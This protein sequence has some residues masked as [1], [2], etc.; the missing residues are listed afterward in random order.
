MK[1]C[2]CNVNLFNREDVRNNEGGKYLAN[3]KIWEPVVTSDDDCLIAVNCNPIAGVSSFFTVL[4]RSNGGP[5]YINRVVGNVSTFVPQPRNIGDLACREDTDGSWQWF[6]HGSPIYDFSFACVSD[7]N[8]CD[9]EPMEIMSDITPRM[10]DVHT[11]C[12]F[13]TSRCKNNEQVPFIFNQGT[14]IHPGSLD[15]WWTTQYEDLFCVKKDDGSFKW[16]FSNAELEYPTLYCFSNEQYYNESA[17]DYCGVFQVINNVDQFNDLSWRYLKGRYQNA[18][19]GVNNWQRGYYE[20]FDIT[21][22]EGFEPVIFTTNNEPLVLPKS[23]PTVKCTYN[24]MTNE[25][26]MWVANGTRLISP[27]AACVRLEITP[28][29]DMNGCKCPQIQY[30]SQQEIINMGGYSA[31]LG[32]RY[33]TSLPVTVSKQCQ[34][35]FDGNELFDIFVF[36]AVL[37]RDEA[38]P[39]IMRRFLPSVQ[40]H[41]NVTLQDLTC[42]KE[43][44][45]YQWNYKDSK[46][47]DQTLYLAFQANWGGC[48]CSEFK[49]DDTV[50]MT[51]GEG[52]CDIMKF[53]CK[54][55]L[56][57][58]EVSYI[59]KSGPNV[60][61]Q[62]VI[63]S[64]SSDLTLVGPFCNYDTWYINGIEVE[65]PVASCTENPTEPT[66]SNFAKT[67]PCSNPG[68]F[69]SPPESNFTSFWNKFSSYYP[70][71]E[72]FKNREAPYEMPPNYNTDGCRTTYSCLEDDTFVVFSMN[73]K[74]MIYPAGGK[75]PDMRCVVPPLAQNTVTERYWWIDNVMVSMPVFACFLRD[76]D[77][78]NPS[79]KCDKLIGSAPINLSRY[80]HSEYLKDRQQFSPSWEISPTCDV[81]VDISASTVDNFFLYMIMDQKDPLFIRRFTPSTNRNEL[82]PLP[83]F[84]CLQVGDNYLWHHNEVP[85]GRDIQQV[86]ISD[87][88]CGCYRFNINNNVVTPLDGSCNALRIQCNNQNFSINLWDTVLPVAEFASS[89]ITIAEATCVNKRWYYNGLRIDNPEVMCSNPTQTIIEGKCSCPLITSLEFTADQLNGSSWPYTSMLYRIPSEFSMK[90]SVKGTISWDNDTCKVTLNCAPGQTVAVVS[91][92]KNFLSFP[93]GTVPDVYCSPLLA[94]SAFSGVPNKQMWIDGNLR[95]ASYFTCYD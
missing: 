44:D 93:P 23:N 2:K 34:V 73:Y 9:C 3:Q 26:R 54:N 20:S 80:D 27:A 38:P 64:P 84:K 45:N 82:V 32:K 70:G 48:L 51:K 50:T 76:E 43:G 79:C 89:D 94:T 35:S 95:L 91:R 85:F 88:E 12:D 30:I 8:S 19:F 52:S 46:I 90:T 10:P 13:F 58:I 57:G 24:P 5:H 17:T 74:P 7:M 11:R 36:H 81:S 92:Y 37:F 53:E 41:K 67:C 1:K 69:S 16:Y 4:F 31:Y 28:P 40:D 66:Y 77:I 25:L 61:S 22:D 18:T 75:T 86:L 78:D 56:H 60:G 63:R 87:E 21:C 62:A 15:P 6:F 72:A 49:V 65:N 14:A 29:I 47:T 68:V 59:A 55:P 42:R 33:T 71:S 83:E 39:V